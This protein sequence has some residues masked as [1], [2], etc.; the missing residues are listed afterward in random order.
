MNRRYLMSLDPWLETIESDSRK[1]TRE[2]HCT[3]Q[4]GK[5]GY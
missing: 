4:E 1:I 2:M 3:V 5:D